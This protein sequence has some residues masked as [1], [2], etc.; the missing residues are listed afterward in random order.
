MKK[1]DEKQY[2]SNIPLFNPTLTKGAEADNFPLFL[3][4]SL[5]GTL[6]LVFM[7]LSLA[8]PFIKSYF[9]ITS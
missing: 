2:Q 8:S 1:I 4:I 6:F 5:F 3:L 9:L 7:L